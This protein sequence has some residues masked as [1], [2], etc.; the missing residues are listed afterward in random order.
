MNYND[1]HTDLFNAYLKRTL[2][3]ADLM[4]FEKRLKDDQEFADAFNFH[5]L[6][7][8]GVKVHAR[9]ELKQFLSQNAPPAKGKTFRLSNM[10]WAAAAVIVVIIGIYAVTQFY[11]QP[12]K[13][14]DLAIKPQE[15]QIPEPDTTNNS[16]YIPEEIRAMDSVAPK[17]TMSENAIVSAEQVLEA[18]D[19]GSPP[20]AEDVL[21]KNVAMSEDRENIGY[22]YNILPEKKLKDTSYY[23]YNLPELIARESSS[24]NDTYRSKKLSTAK[25]PSNAN[26][27]PATVERKDSTAFKKKKTATTG[28]KLQVEFWQS[29]LNFKGY[30]YWNNTVQLY[31]AD[32]K[33]A[34]LYQY[35]YQIYLRDNGKVYLLTPSADA[36]AYKPVVDESIIQLILSQK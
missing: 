24:N 11:I 4:A 28:T 31:G 18:D 17:V 9:A 22:D 6:M 26:T 33:T 1:S 23:L 14:I 7:V 27:A 15:Y 12:K 3:E 25:L 13:E 30:K 21:D 2:S 36:T 20:T 10:Q 32:Q 29:P 34:R 19:A 8:E 35:N 16:T 5:Q